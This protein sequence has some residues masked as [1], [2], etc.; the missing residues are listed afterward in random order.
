MS[1]VVAFLL[2]GAAS[3]QDMDPAAL[4]HDA[5]LY[6]DEWGVPHVYAETPRAMAYAFG[7]A[8]AQDHL[9]PMLIAYRA[10]GGRA[11]ELFGEEFADSDAFSISMGHVRL[12]QAALGLVDPITRDLC[13]G[14]ALGVNGYLA[15][16]P[17]SAP[18]WTDGVRPEEVL[19][20]WHAFLM[21]MAPMDKPDL[22]RRPRAMETGNAWALAPGRTENGRTLLVVNPHMYFDGPFRWYEAHLVF[23]D[24]DVYGFTLYGLPVIVQG[25][26]GVLG[27]ALTPN[28]PDFADTFEERIAGP[29]RD[30][31]DPRLPRFEEESVLALEFMANARPYYVRTDEGLDERYA[32]ALVTV[33]GPVFDAGGGDLY[34]W[35]IGGFRDFGGFYQL[36]EMGRAQN[37]DMFQEALLLQQLPCFHVVYADRDGN[38]F[39]LYNATTGTR[40]IPIEALEKREKAGRPPIDW[41]TP[42]SGLLDGTA[43][44]ALFPPDA[45]PY[46]LNPESGYIQACGNPPWGA[47]ESGYLNPDDWPAWLVQDPDTYRAHRARRLLRSGVRNFRDMQSMVYDCLLPGAAEMA[48]LLVAMG[49]ARPDFV[50]ASHPDL[51][52]GLDLLRNWN[53]IADTAAE[54]ATFYHLWWTIV[55]RQASL[56]SD[57]AI[58]AAIRNNDT[59]AQDLALSAAAEAARSMRN[60]FDSLNVPWGSVHRVRRGAREEPVPGAGSGESLFLMSDFAFRDSKWYATYG[61]G[62]AMVVEFTNPPRSVSVMAFGESENPESPHYADQLNLLLERRFK[63]AR[64]ARDEVLRYARTAYGRR[65]TLCPLGADGV[66]TFATA[67]EVDARLATMLEAPAALPDGLAAFTPFVQ[68]GTAPASEPVSLSIELAVPEALCLTGARNALNLYAYEPGL[69]WYVLQGQTTDDTNLRF[70]ATHNAA[71]TYAVFGPASALEELPALQL[72]PVEPRDTVV[73]ISAEDRPT[74]W[75]T[76]SQ[77]PPRKFDFQVLTPL[78]EKQATTPPPR[79]STQGSGARKFRLEPAEAPSEGARKPDEPPAPTEPSEEPQPSGPLMP[80]SPS[81]ATGDVVPPQQDITP[82]DSNNVPEAASSPETDKHMTAPAEASGDSTNKK[83][84]FKLDIIR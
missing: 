34:S 28:W 22:Y 83:R 50:A 51:R 81:A 55:R 64:F 23:G 6:R 7:Y 52:T 33:R 4:W 82:A 45:L 43:W 62:A 38:L 40:E 65:V 27:W 15:E 11:A 16:H 21:S 67:R 49:D 53:G 44:A 20:L 76:A 46:I 80:A 36:M 2:A 10:I 74:S 58:Y 24:M 32:P 14:F 48:P 57:A 29:A 70:R 41:Q 69:G 13:E 79:V 60:E 66:F 31:K 61:F 30:P 72:P 37:L 54:G 1:A 9:E 42:E 56:P 47:S 77:E 84:K 25:H 73:P 75:N 17:E 78:P 68:A 35:R 3:A 8:Q 19:G 71:A 59:K 39:Y 5:T 18:P 26:N 63:F 12:A